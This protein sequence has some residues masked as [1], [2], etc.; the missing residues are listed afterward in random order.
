[1]FVKMHKPLCVIRSLGTV[2]QGVSCREL[3]HLFRVDSSPQSIRRILAFL[4][5]QPGLLHTTVVNIP[6]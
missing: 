3:Q 4:R 1:M 6:T 5:Q 2:G